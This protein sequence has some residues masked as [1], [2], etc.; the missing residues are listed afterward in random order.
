MIKILP[1][2]NAYSEFARHGGKVQKEFES[3]DIVY[4][5]VIVIGGLI[6]GFK[7][8][9]KFEENLKYLNEFIRK[10]S[11]EVVPATTETAEIYGGIKYE[12]SKRGTPI[13]T[14][15]IWIA[16]NAIETG[17]VVITFDKHFLKIP[18][19]RVWRGI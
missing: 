19:V 13:P 2:T 15:D 7:K 8:G 18:G 11:V 4:L 12:L 6:S 5:S 9:T 16:A 17:S 10:P 14:N 3:S 1:D